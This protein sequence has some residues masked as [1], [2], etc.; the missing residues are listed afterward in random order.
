MAC[1][2]VSGA[3]VGKAPA[4]NACSLVW[5]GLGAV[6]GEVWGGEGPLHLGCGISVLGCWSVGRGVSM[7]IAWLAM[8]FSNVLGSGL[9]VI[10]AVSGGVWFLGGFMC[11]CMRV[12]SLLM[13]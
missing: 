5:L 2:I 9:C 1:S 12:I 11:F 3:M 4:I 6:G 10:L 8:A 13:V 7:A